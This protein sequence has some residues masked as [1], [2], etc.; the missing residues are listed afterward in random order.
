[1]ESDS[2]T[3]LTTVDYAGTIKDT[4]F[5]LAFRRCRRRHGA[6]DIDPLALMWVV[7]SKEIEFLS[8]N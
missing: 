2:E 1:M 7:Q 4:L 6:S 8:R 5:N 3:V